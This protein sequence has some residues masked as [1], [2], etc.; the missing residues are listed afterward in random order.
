MEY[1]KVP[2]DQVS[3]K[4]M[5]STTT[6]GY[7]AVMSRTQYYEIDH[8]LTDGAKEIRRKQVAEYEAK[9]VKA[10]EDGKRKAEER[11]TAYWK[12]HAEEKE[13]LT[14]E[15]TSLKQQI[16]ALLDE[17]SR[18][19]SNDEI[20]Q[21]KRQIESLTA[22]KKSLGLF[23]GKEKKA[24]QD[25]IDRTT[26]QLNDKIEKEKSVIKGKMAPLTK[27]IEEIDNEFNKDR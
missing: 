22:Q 9:K 5:I 16:Q 1:I 4:A 26:G 27:R 20:V 2:A 13:K 19:E 3:Y 15:K 7:G 21:L 25:Q 18:V 17:E 23:A 11:K 10:V 6:N 12:D 8:Y 14:A 24:L